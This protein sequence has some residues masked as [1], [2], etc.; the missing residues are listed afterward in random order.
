MIYLMRSHVLR[1][2]ISVRVFISVIRWCIKPRKIIPSVLGLKEVQTILGVSKH[3][4]DIHN[5]EC[6]NLSNASLTIIVRMFHSALSV[7]SRP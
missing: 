2:L 3:L 5:V 1:W 6:S 7:V 4:L